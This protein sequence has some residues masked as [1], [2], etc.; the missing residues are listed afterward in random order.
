LV[1]TYGDVVRSAA[2]DI[3]SLAGRGET[4]F[5]GIADSLVNRL[6][7]L[8]LRQAEL[9]ERRAAVSAEIE[10]D[11]PAEDDVGELL[12]S[13][14]S[15]LERDQR[16][17]QIIAEQEEVKRQYEVGQAQIPAFRAL[18]TKLVEYRALIPAAKRRAAKGR[19]G[20]RLLRGALLAFGFGVAVLLELGLSK[21]LQGPLEI[22][23]PRFASV[24]LVFAIYVIEVA[25]TDPL[26]GRMDDLWHWRLFESLREDLGEALDRVPGIAQEMIGV[27]RSTGATVGGSGAPP[28]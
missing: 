20:A 24:L 16:I 6:Q 12:A 23:W 8:E 1:N 18:A 28:G 4:R 11:R 13:I 22:A 7:V 2:L 3:S 17:V 19:L 26:L 25:V 9:Q 27:L 15:S 14:K 5:V 21:W 10:A